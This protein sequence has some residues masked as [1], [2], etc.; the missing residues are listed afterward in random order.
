M[1]EVTSFICGK[2]RDH[3][4]D[5]NGP[6]ITGGDNVPTKLQSEVMGKGLR[7]YTWGSVSCSVCGNTAMGNSYWE[8]Q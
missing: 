5:D 8:D 4:C 6:V 1:S 3:K 2:P 7:G